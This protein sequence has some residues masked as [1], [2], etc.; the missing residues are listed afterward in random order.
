MAAA[1]FFASSALAGTPDGPG[2]A[3]GGGGGGGEIAEGAKGLYAKDGG[4]G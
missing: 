1:L 3:A 2:P 4:D